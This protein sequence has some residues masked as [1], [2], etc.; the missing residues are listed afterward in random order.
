MR[1]V[2]LK[3]PDKK[4]RF[5]LELVEQLGFEISKESIPPSEEHKSTVRKRIEQSQQNPERLL[6]WENV[7]ENFK[8]NE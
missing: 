5:F 4:L 6:E 7:Q 3:I 8:F 1:E 2:T